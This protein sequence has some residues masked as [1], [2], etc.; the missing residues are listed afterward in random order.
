MGAISSWEQ[1]NILVPNC[2]VFN[3]TTNKSKQNDT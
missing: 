3:L 1:E 2:T